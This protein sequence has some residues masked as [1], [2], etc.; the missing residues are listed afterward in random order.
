M[1]KLVRSPD[2]DYVFDV[3]VKRIKNTE[4]CPSCAGCDFYEKHL[5]RHCPEHND[6]LLCVSMGAGS[7][8]VR[9]KVVGIY[10]LRNHE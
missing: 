4:V 7:S 9:F 1:N 5:A 6:T 10:E 8:H 3:E 2:V